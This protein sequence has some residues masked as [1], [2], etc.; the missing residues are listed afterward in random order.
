MIKK[1]Q[2]I[3]NIETIK[4]VICNNCGNSTKKHDGFNGSFAFAVLNVSWGY[5][6]DNRDGEVH[7]AHLCQTCWEHIV[8]T[9]KHSDL[10]ATDQY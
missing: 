9:F 2:E 1:E 10:V 6:S 5:F 3:K 8:S 4:D 7:E